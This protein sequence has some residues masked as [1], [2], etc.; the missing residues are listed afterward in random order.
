MKEIH[1]KA[2]NFVYVFIFFAHSIASP[3]GHCESNI[4][5]GYCC[6]SHSCLTAIDSLS[7]LVKAVGVAP[8]PSPTVAM[9]ERLLTGEAFALAEV[10]LVILVGAAGVGVE[11]LVALVDDFP[12]DV[13]LMFFVASFTSWNF[14]INYFNQ[15]MFFI[16]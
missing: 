7:S 1:I 12:G 3:D 4:P 14:S 8:L 5:R 16:V 13:P 2:G 15:K 9:A 11:P 10:E 6:H